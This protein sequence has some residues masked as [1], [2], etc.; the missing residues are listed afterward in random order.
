MTDEEEL[1]WWREQVLPN[2][3]VGHAPAVGSNIE[4]LIFLTTNVYSNAY[5]AGS[6]QQIV[7]PVILHCPHCKKQHVDEGRWA[8]RPHRTHACVDDATEPGCRKA[9]TPSAHRTVGVA[10]L[11]GLKLDALPEPTPEDAAAVRD[12]LSGQ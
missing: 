8:T 1:R 2:F 11:T 6:P 5:P 10:S 3:R 7:I 4:E 9:F 12:M